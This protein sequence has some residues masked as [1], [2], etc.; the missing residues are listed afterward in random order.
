M[1]NMDLFSEEASL[2]SERKG[3]GGTCRQER[4]FVDRTLPSLA[5][6]T[7]VAATSSAH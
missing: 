5:A 1:A 3:D 7:A 4:A 2:G 6:R